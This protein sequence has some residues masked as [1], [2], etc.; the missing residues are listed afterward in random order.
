METYWGKPAGEIRFK[1]FWR[2]VWQHRR[3]L[4]RFLRWAEHMEQ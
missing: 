3:E 2:F 4:A 1:D